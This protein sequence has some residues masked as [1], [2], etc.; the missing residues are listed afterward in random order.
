MATKEKF[1]DIISHEL[2]QPTALANRVSG[3]ERELQL[4]TDI[5]EGN[6]VYIAKL[7]ACHLEPNKYTLEIETALGSVF[8][9]SSDEVLVYRDKPDILNFYGCYAKGPYDTRTVTNIVF[10][11]AKLNIFNTDGTY[12]E[13]CSN[14]VVEMCDNTAMKQTFDTCYKHNI[15]SRVFNYIS[16]ALIP[17]LSEIS[18]YNMLADTS[19]LSGETYRLVVPE[20]ANSIGYSVAASGLREITFSGTKIEILPSDFLRYSS[21]KELTIPEGIVAIQRRCATG[22]NSIHN[23]TFPKSLRFLAGHSF[24][25]LGELM[26]VKFL[27]APEIIGDSAFAHDR[28]LN[29]VELPKG[30]MYLGKNVFEGCIG[31]TSLTIPSGVTLAKQGLFG[32]DGPNKTI[33]IHTAKSMESEVNKIIKHY[34]NNVIRVVYDQP[35]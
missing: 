24:S 32:L 31:L 6:R 26:S 13:I 4:Y 1:N 29:N 34:G 18:F 16:G 27:G 12:M 19:N 20:L 25:M 3:L 10:Y 33:T 15:K 14:P 30:L 8:K 23:I 21:L 9:V 22:S 35:E 7:I 11:N 17:A 28:L 5:I 2:S